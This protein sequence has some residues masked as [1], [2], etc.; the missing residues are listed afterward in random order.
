M[1]RRN[2]VLSVGGEIVNTLPTCYGNKQCLWSGVWHRQIVAHSRCFTNLEYVIS[3]NIPT[4]LSVSSFKLHL[5]AFYFATACW[6]PPCATSDCLSIWLWKVDGYF[7]R[8]L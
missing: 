4:S 6:F 5:E 1:L 2:E 8:V 7:P 3:L